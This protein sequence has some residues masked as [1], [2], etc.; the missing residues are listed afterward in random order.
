MAVQEMKR[1]RK[2]DVNVIG[3]VQMVTF[4]NDYVHRSCVI[5]YGI[6]S[7]L[8]YCIILWYFISR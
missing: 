7:A 4:P 5:I 2:T 8:R 3:I 1:A 6:F